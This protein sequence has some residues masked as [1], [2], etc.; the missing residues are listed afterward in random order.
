MSI[1]NSPD[2][3]T[4]TSDQGSGEVQYKRF[5]VAIPGNN[6]R[7]VEV[8]LGYRRS[9]DFDEGDKYGQDYA[10]ARGGN[11]YIVG[12]VADG[13]SQSFY[14]NLAAKKVS[15]WLVEHLWI[16]RVAPPPATQLE[17]SLK[18]L[19]EAFAADVEAFQVPEHLPWML[20]DNLESV[21]QKSG[22][23][24]VFTAFVLDLLNTRLFLYQVGDVIAI[25][26][27]SD[28]PSEAAQ[29]SSNKGRWSSAGKSDL[30]LEETIHDGVK[31]VVVKS[32]GAGKDWGQSIDGEVLDEDS[33]KPLAQKQAGM[34]DVSFIA[35]RYKTPETVSP[36]PA[37]PIL[38]PRI[39]T[40]ALPDAQQ[41]ESYKARL[42]VKGGCP[43]YR[44]S[45]ER[46]ELPDGLMLLPTGVILGKPTKTGAIKF[47]LMVNDDNENSDSKELSISI[48]PHKWPPPRP[49]GVK[50]APSRLSHG[51]KVFITGIVIGIV[52][53]F[54]LGLILTTLFFRSFRSHPSGSRA[55]QSL[56]LTV[57]PAPSK[58]EERIEVGGAKV[59]LAEIEK[60][61]KSFRQV[62]RKSTG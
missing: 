53:G 36:L 22:S 32:D 61:A 3:V 42:E 18:T 9:V 48:R 47:T 24:A 60:A 15:E 10:V 54:I 56:Q 57:E 39:T 5:T 14:G 20:K 59:R 49:S 28:K 26:H 27:Y 52:A 33:F 51:R 7:E 40:G 41:D 1:E 6:Q 17:E 50:P 30:L 37:P 23:Q 8:L 2:I 19:E 31:G 44:L 58:E 55:R 46:G 62:I 13:V 4:L 21:R 16:T 29:P 38:P 34:D 25:I 11:G 35:V 45:M 43:P 12:V